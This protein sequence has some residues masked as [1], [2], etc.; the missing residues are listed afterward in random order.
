MSTASTLKTSSG[1]WRYAVRTG[2]LRSLSSTKLQSLKA[3]ARNR[4]ESE[5][6]RLLESPELPG[7]LL[8]S[9]GRLAQTVSR[10]Y[11]AN[12]GSLISA[13]VSEL[14]TTNSYNAG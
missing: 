12:F 10:T 1:L 2:P 5:L 9:P 8:N 13:A 14:R 6:L 11:G 7:V 3:T 4:G